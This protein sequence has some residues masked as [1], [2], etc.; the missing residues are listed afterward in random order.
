MSKTG[1]IV[2]NRR[3]DKN[4][5]KVAGDTQTHAGRGFRLKLK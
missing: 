5:P 4:L 1:R 2:T 3:R